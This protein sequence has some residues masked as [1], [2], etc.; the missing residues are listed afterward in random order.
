MEFTFQTRYDTR[1][2]TVMARALRK[3]IRKKHS[4]RSH[5]F[6]WIVFALTALLVVSGGLALDRQT[7]VTAAVALV[8]LLVLLFEDRINGYI[9]K[10]R[11]L[12]GTEEAE[13]VF[14]EE[15]FVSTTE[16]GRTEWK[17]DKILLVA[18]TADFFVFVFSFSHA[19]LYDKHRLQGGSAE[20]FRRFI[21]KAAGKQVQSIK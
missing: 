10:K 3:T 14:T 15:G 19:Q 9:A 1:A 11:L 17:Y 4:R 7:V 8:L 2:L 12:A 21:E 6:G 13:T 16:V 20:D 5:I 18:E